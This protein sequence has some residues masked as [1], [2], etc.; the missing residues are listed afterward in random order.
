MGEDRCICVMWVR[1]R[2]C[3]L[4][5]GVLARWGTRRAGPGEVGTW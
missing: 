5:G 4:G 1:A 3:G 2:V